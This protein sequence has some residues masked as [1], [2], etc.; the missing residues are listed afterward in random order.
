LAGLV[1]CAVDLSSFLMFMTAASFIGALFSVMVAPGQHIAQPNWSIVGTPLV[2]GVIAGACIG[3]LCGALCT[4][5]YKLLHPA[6]NL[7]ISADLCR[8]GI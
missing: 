5:G 6:C 3:V 2:N 8:P 1:D 4:I 7:H